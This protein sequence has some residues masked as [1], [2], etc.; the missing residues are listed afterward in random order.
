MKRI[1]RGS[2]LF[3]ALV[4]LFVVAIA[5]QALHGALVRSLHGYREERQSVQLR[6]LTDAA[7]AATLASL[8]EDPSIRSVPKRRLGEGFLLSEVRSHG[9]G[10]VEVLAT[11]EIGVARSTARALVSLEP[12]GPRVVA[13]DPSVLA[14]IR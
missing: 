3:V 1:D 9:P 5:A 7:L 12:T 14:A 8:S 2:T 4:A 13:W 10:V 6:A 11:G